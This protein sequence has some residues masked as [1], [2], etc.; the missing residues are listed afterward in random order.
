M[1]RNLLRILL[2]CLMVSPAFGDA[3]ILKDGRKV[4]GRVTDKKDH[5]EVQVEGQALT[6]DK[7]EVTQW[8]KSP[9]ELTGDVEN[10][11]NDAKRLYSEA[12][13]MKDEKAADNKFREALPKV[14][15]AREALTEARD[16]FP[17]GYGDLDMQL[18]N[19]MKLMRLVRERI[20][21][22]IASGEPVKAPPV[23]SLPKAETAPPPPE[24]K[25]E[26]PPAAYGMIDALALLA[27]PAKR[28]DEKLRAQARAYL[29]KAADGKSAL[30]DLALAAN[31]CLSREEREWKLSAESATA[32]Q[33]FFKSAPPDKLEALSEKEVGEGVKGLAAKIK[34]LRAKGTDPS[35]D[36]LTLL[37]SGAASSLVMKAGGKTTPELD[38]AFKDLGFEKSEYGAVWGRK[39]GL[40]MDDYRKWI[41]TGEYALGIVQFQKDYATLPELGPKYALGLLLTFKSIQDGRGYNRAAVQFEI[42]GRSAPTPASHDHLVALG[43]SIREESPCAACGGTHK[44]NCTICK[45]KTKFNAQCGKC[46]GSGALNTFRGVAQCPVC[47]GAGTFKDVKCD[48]CKQTG[49]IDCKAKGC[50]H[51]VKPPAF[52]AFADAT[53]CPTCRGKG[54]LTRAVAFPCP[55]C[56]GIGLMLQPK[57]DPSKLLR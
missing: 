14:Q 38:A 42:L 32:L 35:V 22:A 21:S 5:Y 4:I 39:D 48:K 28:A 11:V 57:A 43:K 3:V 19:V 20:H 6:F 7:D 45:G 33:A 49:K 24:P 52:E 41:T 1:R 17:E 36:A 46:G 12:V 9:R 54:I 27:D 8:I 18:V 25:V 31:V 51:E 56:L 50:E 53:Q 10:L 37:A 44:I 23:K 34:D 47:K 55:E 29:K 16:L 13:D 15:K 2:V 26:P 40:A 30:S